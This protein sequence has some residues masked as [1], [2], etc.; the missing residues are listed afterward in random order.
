MSTVNTGGPAFPAHENWRI[1]SGMTLRDYFAAKAMQIYMAD[2]E[3]IALY[4]QLGKNAK[5]EIA[6]TAYMMADAMLEARAS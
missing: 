4:S 6:V 3:L 2:Q 1:D 5:R